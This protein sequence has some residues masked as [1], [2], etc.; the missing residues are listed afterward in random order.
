MSHEGSSSCMVCL[1]D[2]RA[3]D[4]PGRTYFTCGDHSVTYGG[5]RS[6]A[7][8]AA[9]ALAA[10]GIGPGDVVATLSGNS[11]AQLVATHAC[12]R[13]GAIWAPLNAS[14]R[15]DDL[16]DTLRQVDPAL[17]LVAEANRE[18]VGELAD[19]RWLAR[20]DSLDLTSESGA[21]DAPGH[22]WLPGDF[23][24]IIQTGAT[25][26]RPKCIALPHSIAVSHA[27]RFTAVAEATEDDVFFS[28]LQ[29]YHGWLNFPILTSCLFLGARA[30]T[31]EWFSASSWLDEARACGA[32]IVDPFLPMAGA[33]V[34][35]PPTPHDRDHRVRVAVGAYGAH[36]EAD[37]R[38]EFEERFGIP[39]LSTYGT[40]EIG[41]LATVETLHDRRQGS[42]GRPHL[43]YEVAI[44]TESGWT[45]EPDESG[46]VLIR[47]RRPGLMALGYLHDADRTVQ[48]WRDLWVHTGDIGFFDADGYLHLSGR[49]SFWIRRKGENV[50]CTEV[51]RALTTVDGVVEAAV[52]GVQSDLGDQEIAAVAVTDRETTPQQVYEALSQR[53]AY[54]KLPRHLRTQTAP[55]PRT[56]KGDPDRT[57]LSQDFDPTLYTDTR[58]G[59]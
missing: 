2:R 32:T 1:L 3:D 16:A 4:R 5:L 28:S 45:R 6:R 41:G 42:V 20:T 15:R 43:D 50:S 8:R 14:L 55:V 54:F 7:R 48:G 36:D 52:F 12:L 17:L 9:A 56:V 35:R 10:R 53:I 38:R 59:P 39:T 30:V 57:H 25:T 49:S 33:L 46:E 51:E 26:G 58:Q 40:T 31:Q 37:R 47:P 11:V 19:A 44:E 34:A 22:H 23:S 21:D 27:E 18:Q 13:A 24:W 29:M